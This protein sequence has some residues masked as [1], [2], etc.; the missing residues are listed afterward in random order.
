M[1]KRIQFLGLFLTVV[2]FI[3]FEFFFLGVQIHQEYAETSFTREEA[4][5][6]CSDMVVSESDRTWMIQVLEAL[7]D[8]NFAAGTYSLQELELPLHPYYLTEDTKIEVTY[9][10]LSKWGSEECLSISVYFDDISMSSG[11]KAVSLNVSGTISAFNSKEY[12]ELEYSKSVQ[13]YLHSIFTKDLPDI[14][15]Y[16]NDQGYGK[17]ELKHKWFAIV[18]GFFTMK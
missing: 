12:G 10:Q 14:V 8:R 16:Y 15:Y 13:H 17:I 11:N 9:L 18:R 2:A 3:Y 1:R 4:M 6:E 5:K 7:S